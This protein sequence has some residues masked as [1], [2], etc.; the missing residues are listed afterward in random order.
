MTSRTDSRY[1]RR[2]RIVI[3]LDE[4]VPPAGRLFETTTT[5]GDRRRSLEGRAFEGWLGLLHNL[6]AA[7]RGPGTCCGDEPRPESRHHPERT[8]SQAPKEGRGE[9][10][11]CPP[12]APEEQPPL[13]SRRCSRA[14][15]S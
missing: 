2:M 12:F 7:I 5:D 14:S 6:S 13:R 3:D 10:M 11:K 1:P 15:S 4:L 9:E 8:A